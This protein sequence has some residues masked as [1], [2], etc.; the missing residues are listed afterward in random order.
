MFGVAR[1]Q[2]NVH[3]LMPPR[4]AGSGRKRHQKRPASKELK[5]EL[6]KEKVDDNTPLKRTIRAGIHNTVD[7]LCNDS[8]DATDLPKQRE[9][10]SEEADEGSLFHPIQASLPALDETERPH[11]LVS[12]SVVAEGATQGGESQAADR[13]RGDDD[14]FFQPAG[15]AYRSHI[16]KHFKIL[17]ENER[18][19]NSQQNATTVERYGDTRQLHPPSFDT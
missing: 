17:K 2:Q 12:N 9:G 18:V 11:R 16:W 4:K 19:A 3:Y 5:K 10:V 8:P 6:R 7:G 14:R 1:A 13:A 15:N